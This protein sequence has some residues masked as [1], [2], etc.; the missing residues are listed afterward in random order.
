MNPVLEISA[1]TH[2]HLAAAPAALAGGEPRIRHFQ[3]LPL[4]FTYPG[5]GIAKAIPHI[6]QEAFRIEKRI[7]VRLEK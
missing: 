7:R 6:C 2:R 1:L 5:S 4:S 3:V